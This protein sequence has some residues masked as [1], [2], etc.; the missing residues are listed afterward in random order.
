MRWKIWAAFALTGLFWGTSFLW[1]KVA[2]REV[3]PF[4]LVA[5]RI[6]IGAAGLVTMM[7]L[8]RKKLPRNRELLRNLFVMSLLNPLIPFILITWGETH[9]A[10]GMASVLNGTVPLFALAIGAA[11]IPEERVT[12]ERVLGL[13]VGFIGLVILVGRNI[14][15]ST[16]LDAKALSGQIAVVL[17]AVMY[18]SSA[19]YSRIKIKNVAPL[20]QSSCMMLSAAAMCWILLPVAEP[21]FHL[22]RL[23]LTW[24]ALVWLGLLGTCAA[25]SLFFYVL[26]AW[27]PTRSSLINYVFPVIGLILGVLFLGEPADWRLFAGASLVVSGILLVNLRN[28]LLAQSRK[29]V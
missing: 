23:P 8:S 5:C 6:S 1:I 10:S 14:D 13:V 29:L 24:L 21:S 12:S 17:A 28:F 3:G 20:V 18:A 25:F 11:F 26:N 9:I 4:T 7:A 22:P 15:L 2:L 16:T 19:V 27:G